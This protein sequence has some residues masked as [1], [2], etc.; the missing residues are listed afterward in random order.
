M[1][2]SIVGTSGSGK[3]T[4]AKALAGELA[5]PRIEMDAINWQAGWR[6]LNGGDAPEF[7]RRT[8]LATAAENW[9]CDGNYSSVQPIVWARATHLIWLDYPRPTIMRRVLLRSLARAL[10]GRE[11]WPGTGNRETWRRWLD[12]DHPIRW[13]WDSWARNREKYGRLIE[14]GQTAH[15]TVLRLRHPREAAGVVARLMAQRRQGG[16]A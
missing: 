1:R 11:L 16:P 8:A 13:A 7:A 5:I 14:T 12:A 2:I 6:D 9:V 3:T 15:M 4:L 10:D